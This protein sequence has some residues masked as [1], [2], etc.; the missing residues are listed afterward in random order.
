MLAEG[1]DRPTMTGLGRDVPCRP[2]C[3]S[4]QVASETWSS[5]GATGSG[6]GAQSQAPPL[7]TRPT[8]QIADPS[9][10]APNAGDARGGPLSRQGGS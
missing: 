7:A 6:P 5:P 9:R 4:P 1:E 2:V 8:L 3:H 10:P